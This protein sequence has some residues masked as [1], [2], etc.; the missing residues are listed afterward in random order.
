MPVLALAISSRESEFP[1]T[2]L[3]NRWFIVHL[4]PSLQRLDTNILLAPIGFSTYNLSVGDV[5]FFQMEQLLSFV[6]TY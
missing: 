1:P 3:S 6:G 5:R 4:K 2:D